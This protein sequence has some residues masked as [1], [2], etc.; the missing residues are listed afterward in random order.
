MRPANNLRTRLAAMVAAI[1][2]FTAAVAAV[3]MIELR[4]E[5]QASAAYLAERVAMTLSVLI[6]YRAPAPGENRATGTADSPLAPRGALARA[7]M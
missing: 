6:S 1:F 3:G 5:A 4:Q 7:V 2:L